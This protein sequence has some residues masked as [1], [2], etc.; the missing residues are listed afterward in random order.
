MVTIM[1]AEM[2]TTDCTKF[3][4]TAVRLVI[5]S[6]AKM[7]MMMKPTQVNKAKKSQQ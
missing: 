1:A 3:M 6:P 4:G 7:G 2:G 5:E